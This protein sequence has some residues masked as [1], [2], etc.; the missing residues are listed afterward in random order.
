VK[1]TV[2]SYKGRFAIVLDTNILIKI[3]EDLSCELNSCSHLITEKL[4]CGCRL[5]AD[6]I[7]PKESI[8]EMESFLR[9]IE[10]CG[11]EEIEKFR[12]ELESCLLLYVKQATLGGRRI[13]HRVSLRSLK[14]SSEELKR[15]LRKTISLREYGEALREV[16]DKVDKSLINISLVKASEYKKINDGRL[17]LLTT[18]RK[19]R[20]KVHD[21]ASKTSLIDNIV[22]PDISC[23]T[24][25]ECFSTNCPVEC[26]LKAT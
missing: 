24:L 15:K 23:N 5:N 9:R 7:I 20:K 3:M 4:F 13:K 21:L 19:L 11:D 6:I 2:T 18:D 25:S 8:E 1:Y 10:K 17:I 12:E 26:I 14:D 16:V 22:I